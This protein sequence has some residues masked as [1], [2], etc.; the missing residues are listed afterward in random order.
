MLACLQAN[1]ATI[2]ICAI[3]LL[4]V[5]KIVVGLIK[6]RKA[7][8]SSCGCGCSDCPMHGECHSKSE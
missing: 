2:I 5:I 3:L 1:I 7:G 6:D 8:K 4:I